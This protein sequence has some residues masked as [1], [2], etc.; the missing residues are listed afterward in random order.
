MEKALYLFAGVLLGGVVLAVL[1]RSSP[2]VASFLTNADDARATSTADV[3]AAAAAR[4]AANAANAAN[5]L[6]LN[7]P[8]INLTPAP[9]G[10][11]IPA[12][13]LRLLPPGS[14]VGA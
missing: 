7:P 10:F 5:A 1:A 9:T 4:L 13:M 3:D 6:K 8:R 12:S 11:S 2:K 14:I